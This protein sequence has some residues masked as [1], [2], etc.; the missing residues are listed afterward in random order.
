MRADADEDRIRGQRA[1]T[2]KAAPELLEIGPATPLLYS[3]ELIFDGAG[4]P[5]MWVV[6]KYRTDRARL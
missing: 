4:L 3:S 2:G 5:A 1:D 6:T